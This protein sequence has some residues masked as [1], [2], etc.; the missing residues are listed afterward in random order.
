VLASVLPDAVNANVMTRGR[1]MIDR[2]NGVRI[3]KL[4]DVI[5]AFGSNTNSFDVITFLPRDQQ[6][7]LKRADVAEANPRILQTYS[8]TKDRRL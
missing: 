6:E 3:D 4:E 1:E 8:I 2:I 7:V 5:T